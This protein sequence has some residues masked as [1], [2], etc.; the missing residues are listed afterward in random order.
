MSLLPFA[1]QVNEEYWMVNSRMEVKK[2]FN[3]GKARSLKRIKAKNCFRTEKEAKLFL[4]RIM[5]NAPMSRW[6]HF[7]AAV[8]LK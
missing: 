8:G 2:T 7:K 3:S 4:A 6:Q 5:L 1:P